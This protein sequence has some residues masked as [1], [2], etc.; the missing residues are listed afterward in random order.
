MT[1]PQQMSTITTTAPGTIDTAG[2]TTLLT[3]MTH[4]QQQAQSQSNTET[5]GASNVDVLAFSDD[6]YM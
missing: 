5:T 3:L 4:Q 2:T 1:A 6:L